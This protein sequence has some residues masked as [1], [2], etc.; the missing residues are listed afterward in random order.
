MCSVQSASAMQSCPYYRS[1]TVIWQKK[2]PTPRI[3]RHFRGSKPLQIFTKLRPIIVVAC[4][5]KRKSS[6]ARFASNVTV[7]TQASKES[8]QHWSD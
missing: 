2:R 1:G 7:K 8:P 6:A 5:F 3:E 4:A